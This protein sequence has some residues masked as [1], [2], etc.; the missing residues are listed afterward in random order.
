MAK[1]QHYVPQ[2]YLR[3]FS[4]DSRSIGLWFASQDR[5]IM[6]ASIS[7]MASKSYLY[8]KDLLCLKIIGVQSLG[9]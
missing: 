9:E 8:G 5:I 6:N 2:F 3:S 1:N 7:N 4:N